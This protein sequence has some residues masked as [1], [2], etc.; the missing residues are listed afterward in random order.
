MSDNQLSL[1]LQSR[2]SRFFAAWRPSALRRNWPG[3]AISSVIALAATFVST[4]YG[5]PQL[6]YA[7]FFGLAFH[8]LSQ[9]EVCR[10]GIHFCSQTLLRTGVALLGARVTFEQIAHIGVVPLAIVLV[11]VASTILFGCGMA[12]LLGRE[13]L[14]GLL[15]GGA[16]A[17]CGA[18]AALAISAVLPKTKG[19]EEFTLLTVVGVTTLSTLAMICYPLLVHLLDLAQ[20]PAGVFFGGTIHDVAQVVGAGYLISNHTGEVATIVKLARVACLVPVVMLI[21]Y[22]YRKQDSAVE[23]SSTALMP[24]FL[25]GFVVMMTANSL[26]LIP[27]ITHEWINTASRVCLVLAIAALGVKTS[28]Q[29]LASLGWRPVVML[30]AETVWIALFVLG[31]LYVLG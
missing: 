17:I 18:S 28:F 10:P 20:T 27:D 19:N 2:S 26:H 23:R 15:S 5:G 31:A 13:R 4:A 30:V 29:A 24:F 8:F 16:V 12:R 22:L 11:A 25:I 21:G 9:D 3:I 6:L 7:L 1:S 14:E